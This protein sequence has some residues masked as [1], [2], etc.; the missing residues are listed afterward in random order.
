[1]DNFGDDD[2]PCELPLPQI[3]P[4]EILVRVEAIGL[5]FSDVKIIRAGANHPKIWSQ[6]LMRRYGFGSIFLRISGRAFI[7]QRAANG[8]GDFRPVDSSGN[9]ELP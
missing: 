1:M 6:N 5:C 8:V 3:K 7:S 2:K 4:D 9:G